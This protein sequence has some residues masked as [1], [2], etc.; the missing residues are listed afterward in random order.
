MKSAHQC[1]FANKG[2]ITLRALQKKGLYLAI[3]PH[4]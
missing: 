4:F 3:Q 1:Q 2:G